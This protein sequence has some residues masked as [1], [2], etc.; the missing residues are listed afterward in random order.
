M[1]KRCPNGSRRNKKTG[2]CERVKRRL[3]SNSRVRCPN[4]SRQDPPRSGKCVP[5]QKRGS[6]GSK[7][8]KESKEQKVAKILKSKKDL[9]LQKRVDE[10]HQLARP[11]KPDPLLDAERN[12]ASKELAEMFN[13]QKILTKRNK[14][15]TKK[16]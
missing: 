14:R 2:K 1:V 6:K 15:K 12:K 11:G 13:P 3:R 8:S 7:E 10:L 16:K 4:G 5:L 9:K